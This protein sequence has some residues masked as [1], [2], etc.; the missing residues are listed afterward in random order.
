MPQPAQTNIYRPFFLCGIFTVLTVGCVL[1][2][3]ALLGIS[4]KGS[5]TTSTWTPYVLAHANSQLFGWVGFFVMGFALQQH[6]PSVEKFV[7]FQRFSYLCLALAGFG[8]ALRFL[9]EPLAQ[10][11]RVWNPLGVISGVSQLV[12]VL[13]FHYNSGVNRNRTGTRLPW[14]T[15]FVFGSLFWLTLA[16]AVEPIVFLQ[17]HQADASA[18]LAF[19]AKWFAPLR[20][21]QFLG[22]VAMMIYGVS[23]SRFAAYFNLPTSK[24]GWGLAGFW[25]WTAGL[26]MR[27]WGWHVLS[28]EGFG[29][30]GMTWI[31]CGAALLGIGAL[32][33]V[34]SLGIF[35]LVPARKPADFFVRSA[36]LWLLLAMTLVA[37]EPIHL[38]LTSQEFS[39]AFTGAVRHALTVGFISQMIFGVSLRV[40]GLWGGKELISPHLL[41]TA[42]TLINLGNL[43]RVGLEIATDYNANAYG[44]M[45]ASGVI[46]VAGLICWAC[47][48]VPALTQGRGRESLR[49]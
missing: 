2:A 20:E 48:I 21:V 14:Q 45:G 37:S 33:I 11:D 3:V 36:Y 42:F 35:E 8:I 46:E 5:Y 24:P 34:I 22:F 18:S 7:S 27:I 19:V 31:R 10:A 40:V 9:A 1:G 12:A 29:T 17:T 28:G 30:A 39:H 49:A 4:M 41:W 16:A 47:V 32:A 38:R 26:S 25:L 13:I 6:A 23:L 43:L 15:V 44:P